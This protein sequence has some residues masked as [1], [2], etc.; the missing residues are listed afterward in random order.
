LKKILSSKL[1]ESTKDH[2]FFPVPH[3][4]TQ[5]TNSTPPPFLCFITEGGREGGRKMNTTK[6]KERKKKKKK[7]KKKMIFTYIYREKKKV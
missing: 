4:D 6:K 2:A 5:V 7:K 1:L 3:L